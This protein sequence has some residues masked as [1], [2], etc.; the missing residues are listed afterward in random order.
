VRWTPGLSIV[1]PAFNE[2][3]RLPRTLPRLI[4]YVEALG[5]PAEIVLVDDGSVDATGDVAVAIAAARDHVR[6]L[7]GAQ[8][9]GKGASVRRGVLAT[10]YA[11]VLFTDADL[12]AP[13]A[14]AAKLRAA[15]AAGADVAI[16]SRRVTGAEVRVHQPWGRALAGRIFSRLVAVAFL[17]GI[18]D[19]QC[20]FKAFRRAAAAELFSRQRV[21]RFAF[22]VEILWLARRLGYRI[23]EVPVAWRDDPAS[24]IRLRRDVPGMLAD[25]AGVRLRALVGGYGPRGGG[26]APPRPGCPA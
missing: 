15:L 16:G 23:A 26:A 3:R 11:H 25:L 17:P 12:S 14:E 20:G 2:A 24:H 4:G 5:E 8:N 10:R 7:R 13:I 1:V 9:R 6:V 18:R 19:S 21:E 22:D